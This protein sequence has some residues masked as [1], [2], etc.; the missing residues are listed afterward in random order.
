MKFIL[1]LGK[2]HKC[3]L[4]PVTFFSY[5]ILFFRKILEAKN[6]LSEFA[7]LVKAP[8]SLITKLESKKL[9]K[10]IDVSSKIIS[11]A[12]NACTVLKAIP[13]IMEVLG[14]NE[15]QEMEMRL[16]ES[17]DM[18]GRRITSKIDHI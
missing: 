12:S 16:M 9:T 2:F 3:Q 4:Q 5:N 18:L 10:I 17:I 6:C 15:L 13:M 1:F 14:P 8:P 11:V 7:E